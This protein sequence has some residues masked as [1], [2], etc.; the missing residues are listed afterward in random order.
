MR[1]WLVIAAIG[2]AAPAFA[3]PISGYTVFELRP[4][5]LDESV[6]KPRSYTAVVSKLNA[7]METHCGAK[8]AQWN[9]IRTANEQRV[10]LVIEPHLTKIHFVGGNARFWLGPLKGNSDIFSTVK[11]VDAASGNVLAQE[12]FRGHG[13][14]FKGMMT[15]GITDN[16]MIVTV[17]ENMCDYII[18][19][20]APDAQPIDVQAVPGTDSS[21]GEPNDDLYAQLLK[22]DDLRKRGILTETEFQAQKQKL[23]DSTPE[24]GT[25]SAEEAVAKSH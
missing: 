20:I 13:N 15:I 2:I 3:D 17:A 22:L 18:R 6:P 12:S 24:K 16:L 7:N 4:A 10:V 25:D 14:G 9:S 1:P 8:I 21:N 11:I 5:I 19:S 23:L